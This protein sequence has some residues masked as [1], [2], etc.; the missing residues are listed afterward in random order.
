MGVAQGLRCNG[1]K[2]KGKAMPDVSS[3][4]VTPVEDGAEILLDFSEIKSNLN[5]DEVMLVGL[6]F[7]AQMGAPAEIKPLTSKELNAMSRSTGINPASIEN[8]SNILAIDRAESDYHSAS[9]GSRE[10]NNA[11]RRWERASFKVVKQAQTGEE[12]AE[13]FLL[14]PGGSKAEKLAAAKS[15][16]LFI[17]FLS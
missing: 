6:W 4:K 16:G 5:L 9:E 10:R 15:V 7:E 3:G 2:E 1:D 14:T 17:G 13:A 11:F 8:L 12:L